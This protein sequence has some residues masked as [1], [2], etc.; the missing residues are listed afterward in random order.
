MIQGRVTT[1]NYQP[2]RDV[3]IKIRSV[4]HTSVASGITRN[5]AEGKSGP[6]GHYL[7][8]FLLNEHES[9]PQAHADVYLQYTYNEAVFTPLGARSRDVLLSSL[10]RVLFTD[11]EITLDRSIY[12]PLRAKANIRLEGFYT[13]GSDY[14]SFLVTPSFRIGL[15]NSYLDGAYVIGAQT[16]PTNQVVDVAGNDTTRFRIEKWKS[17]QRTLIDTAIYTPL[18]QTANL[19]FTF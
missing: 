17:G 16:V 3:T 4:R 5:I 14:N 2:V 12:L 19:V 7:L 10:G 11:K 6:D 9:G 15:Y 13:S 18:T 1:L 8:K